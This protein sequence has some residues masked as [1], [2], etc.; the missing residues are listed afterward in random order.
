MLRLIYNNTTMD[1]DL[2]CSAEGTD[3]TRALDTAVVLSLFCDARAGE[4]DDIPAGSDRRGWWAQAYFDD[5][6]TWGSSL[7]QV[8]TKKASKSTLIY[9]QRA[10]ERS[11]EWMIADGICQQ[12]DVETW[13]LEGRQGYLGILVKLYKPDETAPQFVGSWEVYYGVG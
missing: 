7:W 1:G 11:L 3:V 2:S 8:L 6:D 4:A 10:C 12:V 13:W 5:D 9:A